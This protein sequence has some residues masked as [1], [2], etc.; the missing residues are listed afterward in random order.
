MPRKAGE[1]VT[2]LFVGLAL[3]F[4]VIAMTTHG[5]LVLAHK[6]PKSPIPNTV[7]SMISYDDEKHMLWINANYK[8]SNKKVNHEV[9]FPQSPQIML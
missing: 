5:W 8:M 3:G 2:L 9:C 6:I 1:I 4:W 7:I